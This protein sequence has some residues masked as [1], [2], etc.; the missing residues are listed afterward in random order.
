MEREIRASWCH[1]ACC[2]NGRLF[3]K[4]NIA[5]SLQLDCFSVLNLKLI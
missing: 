5:K 3:T 2:A 1:F 4:Q